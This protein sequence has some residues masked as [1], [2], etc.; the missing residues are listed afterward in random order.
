MKHYYN[1]KW[2]TINRLAELSGVSAPAIRDRLRRGYSIEQAVCPHPMKD[3]IKE[4]ILAS[5]YKD[6]ID[7]K[8]DDVYQVYWKWCLANGFTP[9]T[10]TTFSRQLF[11]LYGVYVPYLKVVP[12][13]GTR[14]IRDGSTT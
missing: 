11:G 6:W 13:D 4:F 8:L 14:Y 12:M 10:K 7:E 3:S 2:Y 5:Y 1:G 9:D